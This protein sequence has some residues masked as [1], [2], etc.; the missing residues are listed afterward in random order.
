M[1]TFLERMNKINKGNELHLMPLVNIIPI[2]TILKMSK[3]L[4]SYK[5]MMTKSSMLIAH[6][7]NACNYKFTT[8]KRD[9][10]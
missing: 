6:Y 3:I 7:Q 10:S 2:L 9:R 5:F 4:Y 8:S 1:A